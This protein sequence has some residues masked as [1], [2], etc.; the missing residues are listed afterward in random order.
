MIVF[1]TLLKNDMKLF[2][3]DWKA[4]L[5]LLVMPFLFISLFAYALSP[6]LGKNNF[7]DPFAVALVDK[8]DTVQ[9]RMI[10]R[11]LDDITVFDKVVRIPENEA[12]KMLADN[13][14]AAIIIIPGDFSESL[15]TGKNTPVTV[16]GNKA[17]P[18]QATV[19]KNLIESAANLVTASQ[20]A[21]NSIYH[22]N[23]KA[24]LKGEELE[25]QFNE[26]TMK[27]FIESLA[28]TEI[29]TEVE[30]G[31]S[32]DLTPFEYYTSALLAVF[33]MFAG[34]P[35]MKML[36][37]ERSLCIT[38]RMAA[39]P[40]R[41]WQ[42]I[43]SKFIV[44]SVLC[45]MQFLVVIILTSFVFNN[46]WGAPVK[47]IIILFGAVIFAVSAWSIFVAAI[48]KSP[49]TADLIG[50]LGILLMAVL[51]GSIYPLTTMP[52]FI[53]NLSNLTINKWAMEGFMTIFSGN[54]AVRVNEQVYH[55]LGIGAVL[56]VSAIA[57]MKIRNVNGD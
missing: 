3:K 16:I 50:N 40:V 39:S 46:Y 28:R 4:V 13:K 18:L 37:S 54:A 42:V 57:A 35:G 25:N 10:A 49:S 11:Q 45:V 33:L 6:Y 53:R 36:V 52:E 29:F 32:L 14:I 21:I 22:Y 15:L 48:S 1:F 9:T 43:V 26:S 17:M 31:Q 19:V 5:L 12:K 38:R 30:A 34:M 23:Q 24:G 56:L 2:F 44:S 8:E 7:I 27:L 41:W 51:G 20:S 55:L 47:S